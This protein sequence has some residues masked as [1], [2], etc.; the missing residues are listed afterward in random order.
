MGR[1][2]EAGAEVIGQRVEHLHHESILANLGL[3]IDRNPVGWTKEH[4]Q[5]YPV[6]FNLRGDMEPAQ[7]DHDCTLE[8]LGVEAKGGAIATAARVAPEC[9]LAPSVM[10]LANPPF[11]TE[12]EIYL[13]MLEKLKWGV[14]YIYYNVRI[15]VTYPSLAARQYPMTF[16]EIR[17]GLVRGPERIVTMNDGVY[18]W[19]GT[20]DL[21]IV[22]PYD[23]RGAAG[24][25][26]AVT[27]VDGDGVRTE[28]IFGKNES[29]VIEPLPAS[30]EADTPV[31][32]RVL[33]FDDDDYHIH[34][35]GWRFRRASRLRPGT[36]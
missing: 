13:D 35:G 3:R 33:K 18:G 19:P 21:H 29:A 4:A 12:R 22:Y 6:Q 28:L 10:S 5:G 34:I 14:L 27:T 30:L 25:N 15:P 23:D 9:H 11:D 7:V 36:G 24:D 2:R 20:R 31:N 17:S 16:Q 26:H 1:G 32:V 8:V